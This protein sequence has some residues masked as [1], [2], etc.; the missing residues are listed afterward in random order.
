MGCKLT[1]AEIEEL[2]S[3]FGSASVLWDG[4]FSYA[5]TIGPDEE[6]ITRYRW[7]ITAAVYSHVAINCNVTPKVHLMWKH[8]EVN[9]RKIPGGLG[10][11]REDWV[12]HLHQITSA[13]R[14]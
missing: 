4:A 14:K 2:C 1:N 6:D 7:Y 9:M 13:K 12:E 11:K 10:K 3:Q 8:V 5:S